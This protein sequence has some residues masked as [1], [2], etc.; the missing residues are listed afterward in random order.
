MKELIEKSIQRQREM[1]TEN[2]G[3]NEAYAIRYCILCLEDILEEAK[4]GD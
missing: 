3:E 2:I 4:D 1:L